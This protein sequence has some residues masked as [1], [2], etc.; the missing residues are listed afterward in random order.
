ME[1]GIALNLIFYIMLLHF[2]H[3][4]LASFVFPSSSFT[5]RPA[6]IVL[7]PGQGGGCCP[8]EGPRGAPQGSQSCPRISPIPCKG[9]GML[10]VPPRLCSPQMRFLRALAVCLPAWHRLQSPGPGGPSPAAEPLQPPV[11][12]LCSFLRVS[13]ERPV[14]YAPC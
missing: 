11:I 2:L 6:R 10:R 12:A 13:A 7:E 5:A 14:S 8:L 3:L 4:L 1:N 9:D